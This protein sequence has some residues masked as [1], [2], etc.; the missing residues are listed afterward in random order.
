MPHE[1]GGRLH[2]DEQQRKWRVS[3][4]FEDHPAYWVTWVGAALMAA[5]NGAWLHSSQRVS[6]VD[7][8]GC[9]RRAVRL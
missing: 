8:F 6:F 4:E 5:W 9:H 7:E 1:R 2:F 3:R